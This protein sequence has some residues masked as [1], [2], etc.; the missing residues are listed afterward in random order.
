MNT[1]FARVE[2]VRNFR[3]LPKEFTIEGGELTPTF[4]I[5][6]NVVNEKY[7]GEIDKVYE[8]GQAI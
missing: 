2:H 4:K 7:A 6:R 3:I 1:Q 5:K 8:M